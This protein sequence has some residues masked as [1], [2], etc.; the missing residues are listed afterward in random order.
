MSRPWTP[1][2]RHYLHVRRDDTAKTIAAA[3]GRSVK[4]VELQRFFQGLTKKR[5]SFGEDFARYFQ[6][7]YSEGWSD[8]DI[9]KGWGCI[10]G[11]VGD[12]RR[13]LKLPHNRFSR[14]VRQKVA[15]KTLEQAEKA[16]VR[17]LAEVRVLA[18]RNYASSYGWPEDLRPREVHIL[19]AIL[20]HG[21]MTRRQMCDAIGL[22]WHGSRHSL[23]C[24]HDRGGYVSNLLA[25]GLLVSLGKIAKGKGK[26]SSRQVYTVPLFTERKASA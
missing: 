20:K 25:R 3:L 16:G 9:A 15:A 1:T 11:T 22:K 6:D 14:H 7:R 5:L 21:P 12:Y 13:R 23:K 19:N 2:E 26:G 8:E 24:K 4:A 10:R 18:F 17:N